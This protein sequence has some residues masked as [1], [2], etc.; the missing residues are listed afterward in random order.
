MKTLYDFVI[1]PVPPDDA[2]MLQ[3]LSITTFTD[4]YE[5]YNTEEDMQL[6]IAQHFSQDILLDELNSKE[7]FFFIAM[8][9]DEPAAY[10]KLRTSHELSQLKNKKNIELERIYVV[11]HLQGTGLGNRLIQYGVEFA[12][13]KGYNTMWLGVWT[14]NEKAI[15]F[16]K[17]CGFEIF[18]E[19][20]FILGTDE[21]IDWLMKRELTD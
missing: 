15:N 6:Y 17:K 9:N 19:H 4:T 8:L 20:E 12:Q 21:Q 2:D 1:K 7:N 13:Q 5:E 14:R 16:Y 3:Q 18:G 11:K 10:I